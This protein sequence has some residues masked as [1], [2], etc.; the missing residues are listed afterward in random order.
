MSPRRPLRRTWL[1]YMPVMPATARGHIRTFK[2]SRM[3]SSVVVIDV[4]F[5]GGWPIWTPMKSAPAATAAAPAARVRD[6]VVTVMAMLPIVRPGGLLSDVN[7][8]R[9]RPGEVTSPNDVT[10]WVRADLRP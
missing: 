6:E 5:S 10:G 7:D 1:R 4:G 3:W 8:A 2:D 9:S